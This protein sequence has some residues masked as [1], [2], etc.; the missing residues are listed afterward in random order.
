MTRE[1]RYIVSKLLEVEP[2]K[3]FTSRDLLKEAWIQCND[4][5]LTNYE[6][7]G[8]IFR[9]NSTDGRSKMNYSRGKDYLLNTT[10]DKLHDEIVLSLSKEF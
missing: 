2:K 8:S 10:S 3:R 9:A 4:L 7:A 6:T 5:P 1:S